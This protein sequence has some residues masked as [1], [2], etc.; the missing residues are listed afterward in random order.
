MAIDSEGPAAIIGHRCTELFFLNMQN[1]TKI[2]V[3]TT[4][5]TKTDSIPN[6]T[7]RVFFTR[8]SEQLT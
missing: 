3:T 4:T 1:E 8:A 2:P 7:I 6:H 5:T